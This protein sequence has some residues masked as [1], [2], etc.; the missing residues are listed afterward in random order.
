MPLR[1]TGPAVQKILD[2]MRDTIGRGVWEPGEPLRSIAD[3]A[4][5]AGTS[6]VTMQ[7]ALA[8][9]KAEGVIEG[10]KGSRFRMAGRPARAGMRIGASRRPVW[11]MKRA[12]LEQD[13]FT[14]CFAGRRTLP[15]IKELRSTYGV[16]FATM[17]K[18]LRSLVDDGLLHLRTGHYE[19]DRLPGG[20]ARQRIAL[21][22][23]RY[24]YR[25]Q[26]ATRTALNHGQNQVSGMIERECIARGLTLDI[27]EVDFYNS[28]E[29]DTVFSSAL[30]SKPVLGFVVDLWWNP[31]SFFEA[32]VRLLRRLGASKKPVTILDESGDLSLPPLFCANPL[33]QVF[34]IEGARAGG[35]MAGLLLALGHRSVAYVSADHS[36]DYSRQR[37]EGVADQFT[38]AG[39]ASGVH[40]VVTGQLDLHLLHILAASRLDDRLLRKII[41]VDRTE[42]Q[43]DDQFNSLLKFRQRRLPAFIDAKS[44]R[45]LERNLG[46]LIDLDDRN[47]DKGYFDRMCL[48]ALT[49]AGSIVSE[50]ALD[51]LFEDALEIGSA[52]AWVC[53]SDSTALSALKF[54]HRR[55]IRIPHQI[56]VTGFDNEPFEA[57]EQRLTTFDFNAQGF[58]QGILNFIVRPPKV[59]GPYR[60]TAIDVEG[61]VVE[62]GTT[63]AAC[64][65]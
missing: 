41:A 31:A 52:T 24:P 2:H 46:A 42:S 56:S 50:L 3:L 15:S 37:L 59:R 22:T 6:F 32:F 48:A 14:G 30:I 34:R 58:V 27:V 23:Y 9:L 33:F 62:R 17:Q 47:I 55:G 26:A 8:L 12:Q 11:L 44:R 38:K 61:M 36:T 20:A 1:K 45:S 54:L 40:P 10:T 16:C 21:I 19:V 64:T 63:A 53:V 13:L 35:R 39:Y 18:I 7:K 57:A 49:E 65:A 51:P 25:I 43:T 60:H 29:V 4:A 5:E 28:R